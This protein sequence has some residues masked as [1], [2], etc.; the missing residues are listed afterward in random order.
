MYLLKIENYNVHAKIFN[1]ASFLEENEV[2]NSYLLSVA[3]DF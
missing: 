1:L 3:N 2:P